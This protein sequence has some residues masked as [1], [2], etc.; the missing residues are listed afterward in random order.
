MLGEFSSNIQ[1]IVDENHLKVNKFTSA[2]PVLICSKLPIN[3]SKNDLIICFAWNFYEELF[4]KL[5]VS[6][7]KGCF[8][9]VNNTERRYL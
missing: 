6:S 2:I 7:A 3:M 4:K 8:L 9:N 5:Q 1:F